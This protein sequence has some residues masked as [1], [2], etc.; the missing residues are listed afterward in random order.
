MHD[1]P[2]DKLAEIALRAF[3]ES[4]L[5][6]VEHI[7]SGI[8]PEEAGRNFSMQ[9]AIKAVDEMRATGTATIYMR[10][11]DPRLPPELRT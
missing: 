1:I 7:E 11:D 9:S 8:L 2:L 3:D 10:E 5:M 6:N 4:Q